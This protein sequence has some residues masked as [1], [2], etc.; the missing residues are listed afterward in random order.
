MRFI[1]CLLIL[2]SLDSFAQWKDYSISVKGDTINRVDMKGKKQGPWAI[3]V[4]ELRGERGYEEE[5]YFEKGTSAPCLQQQK[6]RIEWR[7]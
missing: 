4:D 3:H 7:L 1:F 2:V 6:E 5:G